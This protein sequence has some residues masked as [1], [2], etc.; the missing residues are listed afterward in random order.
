M[1][2][3]GRSELGLA[4]VLTW[5]LPLAFAAMVFLTARELSQPSGDVAPPI[6]GPDWEARLPARIDAITTALRDS[7][8]RLGAPVEEKQGSGTLR[9]IHRRYVVPAPPQDYALIELAVSNL[10]QLDPGLTVASQAMPQGVEIHIG[11]DGLLTHTVLIRSGEPAAPPPRLAMMI[12]A[13]GDD[14]RLAREFVGV[15]APVA[16][17]VRPFRPFSK[18]VAELAHHFGR[19]VWI[20]LT[21]RASEA[22]EDE[23]VEPEPTE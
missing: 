18:E 16:L 13:L 20:D 9:W 17:G 14:L 12:V 11:L 23:A 10:Q 8:V 6:G 15:D 7:P 22:S 1:A 19:E 3:R 21:P 2:Q 4:W 5:P